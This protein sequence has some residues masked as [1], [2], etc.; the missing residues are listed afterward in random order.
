MPCV[1]P[2]A[3]VHVHCCAFHTAFTALRTTAQVMIRV[4]ELQWRVKTRSLTRHLSQASQDHQTAKHQFQKALK[5]FEVLRR[6]KRKKSRR[7][8]SVHARKLCRINKAMDRGFKIK[9][10]P[11]MDL[12]MDRPRGQHAETCGY[13]FVRRDFRTCFVVGGENCETFLPRQWW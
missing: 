4:S 2:C 6:W 3:R 13:F 10:D 8:S 1:T 11:N 7:L 12:Q 5:D 9:V